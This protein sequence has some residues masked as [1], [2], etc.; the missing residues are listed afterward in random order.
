L[1][2][3]IGVNYVTKKPVRSKLLTNSLAYEVLNEEAESGSYSESS[4][5]KD[6]SLEID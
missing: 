6:P 4:L 3:S 5:S 2:D 1:S